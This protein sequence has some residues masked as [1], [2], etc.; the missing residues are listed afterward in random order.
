MC[1]CGSRF[2][3]SL[4]WGSWPRP[5]A[6][7]PSRYSRASR[8]YRWL[9]K[10][11]HEIDQHS[12]THHCLCV[13]CG[14]FILLCGGFILV[15]TVRG[16]SPEAADRQCASCSIGVQQEL[17]ALLSSDAA[18]CLL[19]RSHRRITPR[20]WVGHRPARGVRR[21]SCTGR[22]AWSRIGLPTQRTCHRWRATVCTLSA[23]QTDRLRQ[24]DRWPTLP[25][26]SCFVQQNMLR[27]SSSRVLPTPWLFCSM[28]CTLCG[29]WG[30]YIYIYICT[31]GRVECAIDSC[32][33]VCPLSHLCMPTVGL[34]CAD[35]VPTVCLLCAYCGAHAGERI[36][37]P[38][39]PYAQVLTRET[40]TTLLLGHSCT[41]SNYAP[42]S[43][44]RDA[45]V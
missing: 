32:P 9:C 24:T 36:I 26:Y 39:K 40:A 22:S 45:S 2:R 28:C 19:A 23:R 12:H 44:I 17:L 14:G 6:G 11:R 1:V 31:G 30:A 21:T 29:L 10:L 8:S 37:T 15:M 20:C 34:L 27:R 33:S 3:T 41:G 18:A 4:L 5:G 43:C 35:C 38:A 13:L 16:W 7:A 42:Y 25:S